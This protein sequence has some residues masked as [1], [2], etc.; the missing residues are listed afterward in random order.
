MKDKDSKLIWEAKRPSRDYVKVSGD[1][2]KLLEWVSCACND[3]RWH[4]SKHGFGDNGCVGGEDGQIH[5]DYGRDKSG[6]T[7]CE[8]HT[9]ETK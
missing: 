5:L 1:S 4:S 9:Y 6:H 2:K 3:C 7:I 8:C